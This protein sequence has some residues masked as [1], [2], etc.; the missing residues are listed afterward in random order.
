MSDVRC[1]MFDVKTSKAPECGLRN[2]RAGENRF[3][4]AA[5]QAMEV[6]DSGFA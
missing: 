5:A 6:A 4:V 1:L 2:F 3:C